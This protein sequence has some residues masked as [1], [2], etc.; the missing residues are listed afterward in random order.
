[1]VLRCI[2]AKGYLAEEMVTGVVAELLVTA[3]AQVQV[4]A[5]L[6]RVEAAAA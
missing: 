5:V 3:G 2:G 4:E 6:V 1:M